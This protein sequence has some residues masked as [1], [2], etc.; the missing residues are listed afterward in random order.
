MHPQRADGNV[1]FP[2]QR[3]IRPIANVGLGV[4]VTIG[5]TA[6]L[7]AR[8]AVCL[9]LELAQSRLLGAT[10]IAPAFR[11]LE[12]FGVRRQALDLRH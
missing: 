5:R 6:V 10:L 12:P 7:G 3:S 11:P 4:A 2:P 1:G 8:Q 9:C